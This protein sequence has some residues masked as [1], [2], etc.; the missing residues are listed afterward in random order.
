MIRLNLV[1]HIKSPLTKIEWMMARIGWLAVG[2][3]Y[4]AY[5]IIHT[6]Y[7]SNNPLSFTNVVRPVIYTTENI[8]LNGS[9]TITDPYIIL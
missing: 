6:G 1:Q 4:D 3:S 8:S 2:G 5:I 7:T 9:G